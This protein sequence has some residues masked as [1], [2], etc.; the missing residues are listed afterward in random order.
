MPKLTWKYRE[1]DF[2]ERCVLDHFARGLGE[3]T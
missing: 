2:R 1:E 3:S